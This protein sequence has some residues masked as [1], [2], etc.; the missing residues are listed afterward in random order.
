MLKVLATIA[1]LAA[2][3]MSLPGCHAAPAQP[4]VQAPSPPQVATPAINAGAKAP[5][6]LS[7][8]QLRRVLADD[9]ASIW[10]LGYTQSFYWETGRTY[11][12]NRYTGAHTFTG[13]GTLTKVDYNRYA[14]QVPDDQVLII[15]NAQGGTNYPGLGAYQGS[16]A[17]NG[18][19]H[20]INGGNLYYVF[21]PGELVVFTM[22]PNFLYAYSGSS[23]G[24]T[25]YHPVSI[26]GYTASPKLFAGVGGGLGG[27]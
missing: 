17:L 6:T 12:I 1:L 23:S 3:A 25:S 24:S 2:I 7:S 16:V 14:Y 27:K 11:S 18:F 4:A 15:N 9:G 10:G 13:R 19:G 5:R 8:A 26:S 21:G 20:T 22:Y